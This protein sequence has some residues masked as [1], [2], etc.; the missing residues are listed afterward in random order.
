MVN[1]ND[2][3]DLF[4]EVTGE[5]S[6]TSEQEVDERHSGQQVVE[7]KHALP[8]TDANCP[9]CGHGEAYSYLQQTRAAD[10]SETRFFICVDCDNTWRDYD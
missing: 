5:D 2:L 1:D 3:G 4:Q 6:V 8:K 7:D 10:E 9:E